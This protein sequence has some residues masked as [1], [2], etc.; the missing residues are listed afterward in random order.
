MA[1][2]ST[3]IASKCQRSRKVRGAGAGGWEEIM[4]VR[5]G[6]ISVNAALGLA[7]SARA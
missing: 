2:L 4:A 7:V 6:E 3:K 5:S 1:T